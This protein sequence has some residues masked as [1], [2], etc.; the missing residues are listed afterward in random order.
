MARYTINLE[1][2]A[3]GQAMAHVVQLPGCVARAASRE[4]ALALLPAAIRDYCAWLAKHGETPEPHSADD[5]EIV[6]VK[7]GIGPFDPGDRAALFAT[8]RQPLTREELET[9]LVRAGYSRADLLAMTTHLPDR[10]LNWQPDEQSMSIRRVLRHVG[11]AEEWYVS[12]LVEPETLS[13]EWATDESMP[14]F[15]FLQMSRR[16]AAARLRALTDDELA[17]VHVPTAFTRR[18]GE[19]WTARKA[20]RRL[21]EHELEHLGHIRELLA[22][23]RRQFLAHLAAE[24]AELLYLLLALDEEWLT[25]R[26]VFEDYSAAELLA[27]IG[28]W[29]ALDSGRV[30]YA[31]AGRESEIPSTSLDEY[32]EQLHNEQRNWTIEQAVT[33]F[34][35][36]RQELLDV[37]SQTSDE[38]LHQPLY[39]PGGE[40]TSIRSWVLWRIRHDAAHAADLGNWR[41]AAAPAP[42]P[43]P[44]ALLL[45]ALRASRDGIVTLCELVP[46]GERDS[47]PL[48]AGDGWTLK[49]I[50]G[51]IADWEL[52]AI[53]ALQAG[54]LPDMG[55]DGEVEQWNQAHHAARRGQSWADAWLDF[56]R[57]RREFEAIVSGYSEADLARTLSNRWGR[58]PNRYRWIASF[59][60]HEREHAFWLR[61]RLMPHLPARLTQEHAS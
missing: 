13:A 1:L 23:W 11:N 10:M 28:A 52:F 37:L 34:V 22:Q 36:A 21:L 42:A 7:G 31:H 57:I 20:L 48:D 44:K 45:T 35:T 40:K 55:Y 8:D 58:D 16:T 27:H 60:K 9:Y 30:R 32:N 53:E 18:P 2:A 25:R 26:P 5:L 4:Q 33:A 49:D 12:R 43:G 3:D 50:V 19:H 24:R 29:D 51:H 54:E 15:D 61:A 41:Q 6:E 38:Q 47:R 17:R 14:T 56:Q 39:L 46:A 59:I